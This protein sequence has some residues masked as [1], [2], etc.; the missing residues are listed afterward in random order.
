MLDFVMHEIQRMGVGKAGDIAPRFEVLDRNRKVCPFVEVHFVRLITESAQAGPEL[1]YKT[2][3]ACETR[4]RRVEPEVRIAW[5]LGTK[6]RHRGKV[7]RQH[8][9]PQRRA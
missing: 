3:I 5:C 1:A 8:R 9:R 7:D 4:T 6:R 2:G